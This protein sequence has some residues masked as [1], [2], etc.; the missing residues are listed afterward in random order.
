MNQFIS[1][2]DPSQTTRIPSN[3]D[4]N[5]RNRKAVDFNPF[6]STFNSYYNDNK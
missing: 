6:M 1:Y 4:T 2:K 5:T 3:Q